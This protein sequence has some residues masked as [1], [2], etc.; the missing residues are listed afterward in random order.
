[1]QQVRLKLYASHPR[2]PGARERPE[3]LSHTAGLPTAAP[4]AEDRY[5]WDH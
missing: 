2:H 4:S 5:L 3:H 1:M